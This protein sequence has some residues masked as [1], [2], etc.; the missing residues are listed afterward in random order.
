[1]DRRG[2]LG[3]FG[4]LPLIGGAGL[5]EVGAGERPALVRAPTLF[6]LV[7][8][9]RESYWALY[10]CEPECVVATLDRFAEMWVEVTGGVMRWPP[11]LTRTYVIDGLEWVES[12]WPNLVGVAGRCECGG[13]SKYCCG[14]RGT[15]LNPTLLVMPRDRR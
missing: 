2:F 10:G 6:E 4:G 5:A 14:C 3:A 15:G 8:E 13:G 12:P 7:T 11:A 9:R 1:M